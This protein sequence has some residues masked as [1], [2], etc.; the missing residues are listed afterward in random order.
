MSSK[1]N[2]NDKTDVMYSCYENKRESMKLPLISDGHKSDDR[3][4]GGD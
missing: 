1:Y 2:N 3:G 4:G